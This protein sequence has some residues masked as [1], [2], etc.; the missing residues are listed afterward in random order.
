MRS[1]RGQVDPRVLFLSAPRPPRDGP[2]PGRPHSHE[3]FSARELQVPPE[4]DPARLERALL[5]ARA[6]R[7]KGFVRLREG[8]RL[9]QLVG[10]RFELL[11]PPEGLDPALVGRVVVIGREPLRVDLDDAGDA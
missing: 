1:V 6:L 3:D 4:T 11:D 2:E 5:R 10:P 8:V 7:A 9:V